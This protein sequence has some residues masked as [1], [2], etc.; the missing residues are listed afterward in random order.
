MKTGFFETKP[1]VKSSTR[2]MS[3]LALCV[4]LVLAISAV[5][6]EG[7]SFGDAFPMV[8]TLLGYSLGAKS[9]QNV[10]EKM[11]RNEVKR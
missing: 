1:G 3:F 11:N 7:V 6:V 2:L 8:L 5:F 4:G 9:F 10:T